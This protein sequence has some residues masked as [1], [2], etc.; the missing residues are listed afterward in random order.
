MP[1]TASWSHTPIYLERAAAANAF[2]ILCS[3]SKGTRKY[4]AVGR[5]VLKQVP[6]SSFIM[7]MG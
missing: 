7:A 4:E 2:I 3:P 5:L 6:S 1:V